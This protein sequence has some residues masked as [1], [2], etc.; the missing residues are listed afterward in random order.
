M[1]YVV[2]YYLIMCYIVSVLHRR[3]FKSQMLAGFF[4]FNSYCRTW[5]VDKTNKVLTA[6]VLKCFTRLMDPDYHGFLDERLFA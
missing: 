6:M 3:K 2:T 1:Y 5:W 4:P